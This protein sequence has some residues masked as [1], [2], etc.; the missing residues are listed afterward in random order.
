MNKKI[1][2][3]ILM[4]AM[5]VCTAS[6]F[7]KQQDISEKT[8]VKVA[9]AAYGTPVI[10]GEID[11][12]WNSTNYNVLDNILGGDNTFYKGW[13]KVLWDDK[14]IYIFLLKFIR[15]NSVIWTPLRGK[16]IL[17][18][19]LSM[20]I[21]CVQQSILMMITSFVLDLILP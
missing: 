19:F 3:L 5:F 10:D 7:A 18:N 21:A 16:M 2:A 8:E 4:L 12:I 6:A 1:T 15:N 11:N 17:L 9:E 13:F 14:N 20:R